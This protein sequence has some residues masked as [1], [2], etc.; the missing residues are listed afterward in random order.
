MGWV[1]NQEYVK[2]K[3]EYVLATLNL[4][5]TVRHSRVS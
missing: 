2:K 5:L 4:R 3:K 1:Q